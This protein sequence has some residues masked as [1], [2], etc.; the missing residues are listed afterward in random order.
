MKEVRAFVRRDPSSDPS[1]DVKSDKL[2][3]VVGDFLAD[4]T[5]LQSKIDGSSHCI[6]AA[7]GNSSATVIAVDNEG[8]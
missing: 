8:R 4:T 7:A 2:K 6:F 1:W 3:I 5:A